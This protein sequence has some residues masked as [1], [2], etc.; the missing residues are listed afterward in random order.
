MAKSKY[1]MYE[2]PYC[3]RETKME[4]VGTAMG[5]NSSADAQ[6]LWYKCTRCKHTT[7]LTLDSIKKEKKNAPALEKDKCSPYEKEKS[8]NI[9][10]GIYHAEWND[11]GK[12]IR[13][14]KT[15]SGIQ[16]IVVAFERLGER[17]LLENVKLEPTEEVEVAQS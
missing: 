14:E 12:V 11:I 8:Y 3:H 15:S 2:C 4:L 10:E 7:L 1:M 16:S 5:E 17:K 6:K 9:G 13:K